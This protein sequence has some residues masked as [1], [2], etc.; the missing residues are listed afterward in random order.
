MFDHFGEKKIM[1]LVERE[2]AQTS[3][4]GS[5]Q[6]KHS[7]EQVNDRNSGQGSDPYNMRKPH[8]GDGAER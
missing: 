3:D 2:T 4:A 1:T 6:A 8:K 5:F 7:Y